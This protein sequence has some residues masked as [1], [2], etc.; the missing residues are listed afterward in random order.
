MT[1]PLAGQNDQNPNPAG[2][3]QEQQPTGGTNYT[4]HQNGHVPSYSNAISRGNMGGQPSVA[5]ATAQSSREIKEQKLKMFSTNVKFGS[6]PQV[7]ASNDKASPKHMPPSSGGPQGASGVAQGA[8]SGS[9]SAKSSQSPTPTKGNAWERP[10]VISI[11]GK[12]EEAVVPMA[13]QVQNAAPQSWFNIDTVSNS[14][15][16]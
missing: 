5:M 15:I 9:H 6:V 12:L 2:N 10:P 3:V 16:F 1:S 11:G 8:T 4:S 7:P 13:T 14:L